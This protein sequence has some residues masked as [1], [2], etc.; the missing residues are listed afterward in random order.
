MN[1]MG[2]LGG[3]DAMRIMNND[4]RDLYLE[5]TGQKEPEDLSD[6]FKVQLGILTEP[7]HIEWFQKRTGVRVSL[8]TRKSKDTFMVANLD[9]WLPEENTFLE[10]KH[11]SSGVSLDMKARYY[12]AQLQHYMYVSDAQQCYFSIIKG[13]EEPEHCIVSRD[14]D[15]INI[16][17]ETEK[18]F[19]YH[20]TNEIPPDILPTGKTANAKKMV[21]NIL[22]DGMR[23]ADMTSNNMWA[24]FSREVRENVEAAK[25]YDEAKKQIRDMVESD[26]V[27]AHGHGIRVKRDKRGRLTV[28]MEGE[29]E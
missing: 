7:L 23:I 4:W 21:N 27:E 17:V 15:Y 12:M 9:A 14:E 24:H 29:D 10:C 13:N 26:V 1:R 6:I 20:V 11:S 28:R 2:F 25:K 22:V 8:G 5:K 18:A 16:L 19:W 3:T